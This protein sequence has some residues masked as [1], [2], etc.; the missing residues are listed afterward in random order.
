MKSKILNYLFKSYHRPSAKILHIFVLIQKLFFNKKTKIFSE[1]MFLLKFP[2]N[3][4]IYLNFFGRMVCLFL[5]FL[6]I[7]FFNKFLYDSI[8]IDN[9]NPKNSNLIRGK[10][11]HIW[12]P[13]SIKFKEN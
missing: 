12:P 3:S 4:V 6:S 9:D 13:Q 5:N 11:D 10:N 2:P 1:K 8:F 7:I